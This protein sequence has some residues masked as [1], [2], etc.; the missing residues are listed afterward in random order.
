NPFGVINFPEEFKKLRKMIAVRD[1]RVWAVAQGKPV[2]AKPDDSKTGE[3]KPVETNFKGKV[4]LTS[5]EE[6]LKKF[7]LPKGF[8]IN[9]FASER[10]FPDLKTPCQLCFDAKGRLWVCT[11]ESYPM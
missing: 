11:M 7:T 2:S 1:R 8:E 6:S 5:A 9:L 4:H 3:L 10:A